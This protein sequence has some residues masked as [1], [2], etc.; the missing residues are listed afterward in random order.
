MMEI[1]KELRGYIEEEK[2]YEYTLTNQNNVSL[3]V[4]SYGGMI[5]EIKMPNLKG[6]IEDITIHLDDL[7]EIISD[8]PYHG[9]IIGPVAGRIR[10]GVYFDGEKEVQLDQ[11]EEERTLHGGKEGL[12]RKNWAV[13]VQEGSDKMSLVLSTIHADMESGFP[14]NLSVTVTYT[15]TEENDLIIDYDAESDKKTLFSPTNHVYFNLSGDK[16][17]PIYD[18]LLELKSDEYASITKEG[19]ITGELCKVKNR[20][21]DFNE[22][23]SLAFLPESEEKEIQEHDG[24]D[25][26]FILRKDSDEPDAKIYHPETGRLIQMYTDTEAVVVYTH[27]HVQESETKTIPKHS[28]ITLETS[29]LA[30]ATDF[31]IF[32]PILLAKGEH[33]HSQTRFNFSVNQS[34]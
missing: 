30:D 26:S 18:H 8:R 12:D 1:T 14:G 33:F 32:R 15:L 16:K 28:G 7:E 11:N 3:S 22:M 27:N 10:G 6:K 17:N 20:D 25:H 13:K 29:G 5:T 19:L 9:T 21:Y 4:I 24:L 23:K 2:I 34:L 31:E